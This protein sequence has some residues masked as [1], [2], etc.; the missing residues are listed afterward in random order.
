MNRT[1]SNSS[2]HS[3]S[4]PPPITS[5]STF[6][7]S[8][9][10]QM[11]K[12]HR[13]ASSASLALM[14]SSIGKNYSASF[15]SRPTWTGPKRSDSTASL[16]GLVA[17]GTIIGGSEL[18]TL[19]QSTTTPTT[20]FRINSNGGG[21]GGGRGGR[22]NG[23]SIISNDSRDEREGSRSPDYS[24]S[25]G[26]S[27]NTSP[28]HYSTGN[29]TRGGRKFSGGNGN[30]LRMTPSSSSLVS[31]TNSTKSYH[32]YGEY[33]VGSGSGEGKRKESK[34]D[35]TPTQSSSTSKGLGSGNARS[36]SNLEGILQVGVGEWNGITGI[37]PSTTSKFDGNGNNGT[38]KK[39]S[40]ESRTMS[41]PSTARRPN[42]LSLAPS[43]PKSPTSPTSPSSDSTTSTILPPPPP[44]S[45]RTKTINTN[46]KLS[47]LL[48][49]EENQFSNKSRNW[50][51]DHLHI[52]TYP[53]L[54]LEKVRRE[55]F[56]KEHGGDAV[57]TLPPV[58]VKERK[59]LFYFSEGVDHE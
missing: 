56:E 35:R 20:D 22:K 1:T 23:R 8:Q 12:P 9:A 33:K 4:S 53:A 42:F 55:K 52:P 48:N 6:A 19:E 54:D 46:P 45:P 37:V 18:A 14:S 58:V 28:P 16:S 31:S 3:H 50:S 30:G 49:T 10:Q 41:T 27:F 15:D 5:S 21:G 51:W 32:D 11:K 59:R 7:Q 24:N 26:S 43:S 44:L 40:K 36:F 25:P 57:A 13:T 2:S 17:V 39:R 29:S 38:I 47:H 34:S